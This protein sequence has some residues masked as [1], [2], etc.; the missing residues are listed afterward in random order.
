MSTILTLIRK[1]CALFKH[2]RTALMLTFLVPVIMIYVF[3]QVFGINRKDTGPNGIPLAVVNNC[4]NPAAQRLID[5][6][7]AEKGFRVITTTTATIVTG[8]T[9]GAGEAGGAGATGGASVT[10]VTGGASGAGA[11]G[12]ADGAG[13]SARP[14]TEADLRPLMHDNVFRFAVVIP[15]DLIGGEKFG[16]NLK[17]LSNPRN[18]IET[19]TVSG[20]LQKCI[21]SNVPQ[22]LGQSMQ[23]SM[24][25]RLGGDGR[26]KFNRDIAG[27]VSKSFDVSET[28]VL[29]SLEAGNFGFGLTHAAAA[30]KTEG[31]MRT[32]S[33]MRMN[34]VM[35]MDDGMRTDGGMREPGMRELGVAE[36]GGGG[37]TDAAKPANPFG[38]LIRIESEQ[39][40]GRD[41]KSPAAARNIGG[42]AIMFLLFSVSHSAK[43]L[44]DEK[45]AGLFQ[46]M[47]ASSVR[48]A[49]VLWSKFVFGVLLGL[50]QL[51]ALFF[52]G[53]IM[54][55][56]DVVAHFR[57][58]VL[59]SLASSGA[60]TGFGMLIASV[61]RTSS[62]A[63]SLTTL[64]VL[65]MCCLGGAWVPVSFMPG[66]LQKISVFTI[67]Y[68][69]IEGFA[70]VFWSGDSI[71]QLA[72]TLGVL[73]GITAG[74]MAIAWWRFRRGTIFEP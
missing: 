9:G 8:V 25:T 12:E 41:V 64:L 32:E 40:I 13:S 30:E 47:F 68:W 18:E 43:A 50:V 2:D 37:G 51:L 10:G 69:A 1:D 31:G 27:A 52:A 20:L 34:D 36:N 60:C 28:D 73:C 5:A 48:P 56:L 7:R 33:G 72:P 17:L 45:H 49:H 35:R 11:A 39:V 38:G 21:F 67:P 66:F 53:R 6:L 14:L 15:A 59:V 23:E 29:R 22:L 46:R 62:A 63:N 19:Q 74:A 70:Q 44:F 3:G 16:V 71:A 65:L 55:G 54:F 57:A 26:N 58:L 42:W 61:A 24:K 4:A